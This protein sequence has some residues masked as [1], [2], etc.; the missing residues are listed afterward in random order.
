MART[1]NHYH[2]LFAGGKIPEHVFRMFQ[3]REGIHLSVNYQHR[4]GNGRRLGLIS[5]FQV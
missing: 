1:P 5:I 4:N 2:L 3:G